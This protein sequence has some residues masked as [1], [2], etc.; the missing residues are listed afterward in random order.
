M[1][2]N[3]AYLLGARVVSAVT[4]L[5]LLSYLGRSHG[6]EALG[7]AGIGLAL[8][9]VLAALTDAGSGSL[10]IREG[11]REPRRLAMLLG[12]TA[13]WRLMIIPVAVGA[14]WVILGWAVPDHR[15]AVAL[16]ATGLA[17]QQLAELTRGVFIARE[18][19]VVSSV[20]SI[21][22]NI[23]WL[24][25]I[26]LALQVGASLE[27]AFALGVAVFGASTAV[28]VAL[29]I[30]TGAGPRVPDAELVR[31]LVR[32]AGPFAAFMIAGVAYSRLDT[33]L[34]A[35]LLPVGAITAAGAYFSAMRIIGGLEYVADAVARAS[36][37]RL[38]ITH[39][40]RPSDMPAEL[41]SA[42][43]FLIAVSVPLPGVVWA[44][45][46]AL[47][48]LLFGSS[49]EPYAWVIVPLAAIVPL[50][51]LSYLFGMTLTS[52]DAQGRR[53]AAAFVAIVV[54]LVVDIA[55]IPSVGIA[56]AVVGSV[57]A[58]LTVLA[59][60]TVSMARMLGGRL[61]ILL[62]G[63]S[64][65]IAYSLLGVAVLVTAVAGGVSA[66]ILVACLYGI[67]LA[68]MAARRRQST[69]GMAS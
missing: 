5:L 25:A 9:A 44:V 2:R 57:L 23:A 64:A 49:T 35:A 16:L 68:V 65:V 58:S 48:V 66:A 29:C 33:F 4:T 36:F 19:M 27:L 50:R 24:V 14:L 59:I 13:A 26:V 40:D 34:V 60:Y 56:G 1:K 62:V 17:I 53:A 12:A 31:R 61:P 46:P 45:G 8:G 6:G 69:A 32:V 28:G 18:Q 21:V 54:V 22:E 11:A 42:A 39:R 51:F 38:V 3:A 10:L 7:V 41:T 15:S 20:H 37:P 63:E 30:A 55:L 47:M 52:T 67:G 43:R